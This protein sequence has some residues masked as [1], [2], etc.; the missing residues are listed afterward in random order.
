VA[1]CVVGAALPTIRMARWVADGSAT[2]HTDYWWMLDSLLGEGGEIRWEGL[3]EARNGH[4]VVVDKLLYLLNLDLAHGSN[5]TLGAIVLALGVA[6]IGGVG[7][8]AR[9]T[10]GLG[11]WGRVGLVVASAFAV[12]SP[13]GGWSYIK[14][15]SGA[16]WLTADLSFVAALVAQQRRWRVATVAFGLL[17]S[18]SYGT[19]LAVWPALAVSGLVRDRT[20]WRAQWPVWAAGAVVLGLYVRWRIAAHA[21]TGSNGPVAVLR[22]TAILVLAPVL[23]D[24]PAMAVAVCAA[25][26]AGML[27]AVVACRDRIAAAA[28]WTGLVVFGLLA[29]ALVARTRVVG[30]EARGDPVPSRYWSI[31]AWVWIGLL[32]MSLVAFR[33]HRWRL[34]LPALLVVGTLVEGVGEIDGLSGANENQDLLG[35]AMVLGVADGQHIGGGDNPFP[36]ITERARAVGHQPFDGSV[37]VGCG[38]LGE[39][40]RVEPLPEGS[41]G[42]VVNRP[43]PGSPAVLHHTGLVQIPGRRIDCV[44]V[45]DAESRVVGAGIIRPAG[46][47][48]DRIRTIAPAQYFL[49]VAVRTDPGGPLYAIPLA[50]DEGG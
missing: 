42:W 4:P 32:G 49:T 3:R 28:P 25:V 39:E 37:D 5:L 8:L 33:G 30:D 34:L 36:P 9:G 24:S 45:V 43:R 31:S 47:E 1:A 46:G 48:R 21:G 38:L 41:D 20:R 29:T 23:P 7:L 10:P 11:R 15:M 6:L 27:V 2:Q 26:V 18:I 50:P 14:A 12:M 35:I 16:A 22:G 44:V 13:A 19:G 17:A 40:V